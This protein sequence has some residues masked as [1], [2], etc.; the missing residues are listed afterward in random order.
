MKKLAAL[1][2]LGMVGC[3]D[4]MSAAP[5]APDL[6]A[7]IPIEIGRAYDRGGTRIPVSVTNGT[8]EPQR[9]IK[10]ECGLYLDGALIETSDR[11]W[12]D[13]PAGETVTGDLLP[14]ATKAD[15]VDCR[16]VI[17]S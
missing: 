7:Q 15:R 6:R 2:V 1:A 3:N 14:D 5:P 13:V 9:Y 16:P 11:I 12:T 4:P 10:I 8:G 17:S